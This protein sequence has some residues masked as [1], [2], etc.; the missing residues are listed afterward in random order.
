MPTADLTVG[1][2]RI[3]AS[4]KIFLRELNLVFPWD[5]M[6]SIPGE[7]SIGENHLPVWAGDGWCA[8]GMVSSIR[9]N[10]VLIAAVSYL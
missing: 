1:R 2:A 10:C 5:D 3:L 7:G 6:P 9:M 4:E 8:T